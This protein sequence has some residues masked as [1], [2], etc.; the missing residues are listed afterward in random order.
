MKKLI[1]FILFLASGKCLFAQLSTEAFAKLCTS[2]GLQFS[3]SLVQNDFKIQKLDTAIAKQYDYAIV[4]ND[5]LIEYRYR[6]MPAANDSSKAAFAASYFLNEAAKIKEGYPNIHFNAFP[7]G[8]IEAS[9]NCSGGFSSFFKPGDGMKCGYSICNAYGL[10]KE[11]VGEFIVFVLANDEKVL[12]DN[13]YG[14]GLA[15]I[16][17]FK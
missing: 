5:R 15:G 1:L 13:K 8:A 6:I 16:L 4:S 3:P 17:V 14:Y 12:N 10:Y 2:S 7:K 9:F 11:N